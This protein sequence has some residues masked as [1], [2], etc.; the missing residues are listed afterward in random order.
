VGAAAPRERR[1]GGGAAA[2]LKRAVFRVR[3][4]FFLYFFLVFQNCFSSLKCVEGTSIN[5]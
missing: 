3:V 5:K 2:P 1:K 4:F